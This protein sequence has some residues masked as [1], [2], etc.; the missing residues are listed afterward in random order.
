[1]KKIR[2]T[3]SQQA[4]LRRLLDM[5]YRP[6][7]IAEEIGLT[8]DTIYRSHIPAGAPT[9]T[10]QKGNIWIRG[11]AYRDWVKDC[12]TVRRRSKPLSLDEAYCLTCME[13]RTIQNPK[14]RPHRKNISIKS[15]KCPVCGKKINRYLPA[16]EVKK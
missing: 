14:I 2:L 3:R 6:S 16:K 9:R 5:E 1:M 7:E 8:T 12:L 13:V 4:R 15:G 11:T 10:D